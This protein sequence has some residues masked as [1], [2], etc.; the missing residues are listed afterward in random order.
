M[1]SKKVAKTSKSNQIAP[2]GI[3]W[4]SLYL[5]AV[6]LVTLLIVLFSIISLLNGV[7]DLIYPDPSYIDPYANKDNLP[8]PALLAQQ[9][10]NNRISA[11]KNIFTTLITIVITTPIYLYHW[12]QAQRS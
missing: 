6:S 9:E 5:Y 8:N 10:E 12:R 1:V 7:I 4:R 2:A 3:N 11:I